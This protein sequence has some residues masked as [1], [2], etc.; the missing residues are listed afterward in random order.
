M[1]I[2]VFVLL[3][4][5]NLQLDAQTTSGLINGLPDGLTIN[6]YIDT[7]ISYDNDKSGETLRQFSATA[8]FRDEFKLNMAFIAAR[9]SGEKVRGNLVIQY[10]DIPQIN[11]PSDQKYIQ[12]A[13]IGFRPVKNFWI[14][15]GYFLTHI[16][17]ESIIPQNNYFTSLALCTYAEPFFQSGIRFT[18]SK[19]ENFTGQ[20]HLLNGYNVFTDNNHNKSIGMTLD[21][22]PAKKIEFIFN[23]IMGNEIPSGL[24][25]KTRIYNNLVVKYNP[26]KKLEMLLC[27]DYCTQE[28]S[29]IS[30]TTA[31][32]NMFSSFASLRYRFNKHF[33]ASARFEQFQDKEGIMLGIIGDPASIEPKGLTALGGTIAIEY[34]VVENSYFR[35]EGRYLKTESKVFSNNSGATDK[36]LEVILSSGILF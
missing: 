15:A 12:E 11:W 2:L 8:P 31:P 6:G 17:A 20:I 36:R 14:D 18:Y 35:I 22:K 25:G 16:G 27:A 4:A 29:K 33:A 21:F 34:N 7:Y 5:S 32:A 30:D 10:G 13:N 3:I 19:S 26:S 9:Y 23:N 1:R 24:P 28:K